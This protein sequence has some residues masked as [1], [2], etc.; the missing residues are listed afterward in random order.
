MSS[1]VESCADRKAELLERIEVVEQLVDLAVGPSLNEA[2]Y[3]GSARALRNGYLELPLDLFAGHGSRLVGVDL[4]LAQASTRPPTMTTDAAHKMY[5]DANGSVRRQL[6]EAFFEELRIEKTLDSID[7]I[8]VQRQ[9]VTELQNAARLTSTSSDNNRSPS[10]KAGT[11]VMST[12][13]GS[14]SDHSSG[15]GLTKTV[16]VDLIHLCSNPA[17]PEVTLENLQQLLA[18]AGKST[19]RR[20]RDHHIRDIKRRLGCDKIQQLVADYRAGSS[21]IQLM[22]RYELS[23]SSV[24]K[25]LA[26]NDVGMR[27][28][29]R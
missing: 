26:E 10:R 1:R 25:L 7:A 5:R 2:L 9:F 22:K 29:T 15:R 11:S 23:K 8:G 18:K 19:N 20:P 3:L 27:P 14:L 6:L 24:L 17:F 4:V 13:T 12:S 21:T 28:S 16:F